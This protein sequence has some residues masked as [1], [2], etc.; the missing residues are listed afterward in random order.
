MK[1]IAVNMPSENV[2]LTANFELIVYTVSF[3][4]EDEDGNSIENAVIELG[5]N[6]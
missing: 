4:V 2:N 1:K 6:D 5:G 3:V